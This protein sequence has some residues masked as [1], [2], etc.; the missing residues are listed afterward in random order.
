MTKFYT[1]FLPISAICHKSSGVFQAWR[2]SW[3]RNWLNKSRLEM[4][5]VVQIPFFHITFQNMCLPGA[6]QTM[7]YSVTKGTVYQRDDRWNNDKNWVNIKIIKMN[8][9]S[10]E[11]RHMVEYQRTVTVLLLNIFL[12]RVQKIQPHHQSCLTYRKLLAAGIVYFNQ[13][14]VFDEMSVS[15]YPLSAVL[16]Q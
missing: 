7:S 3:P 8:F 16:P 13:D 14:F 11:S 6:D 12:W 15:F 4:L 9:H 10:G 1:I 5:F 2:W